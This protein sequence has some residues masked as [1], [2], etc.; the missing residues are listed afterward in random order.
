LFTTEI[1][2]T[3]IKTIETIPAK[4]LKI[5]NKLTSQRKQRLLDLLK[6]N[7]EAFAWD[8]KEMK[9]MHPSMC[10]HHIYIKE[11][12]KHVREPRRRMNPTMK[13]IVKHELQKLLDA[14]FIY[15]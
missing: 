12:Y 4:E 10:T 8:Y 15:Q 9:G 7:I 14:R 3:T 5:S 6:R 11:D 1:E 13:F 2:Y